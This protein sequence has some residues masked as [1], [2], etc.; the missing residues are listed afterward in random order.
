MDEMRRRRKEFQDEETPEKIE[1][2]GIKVY[3]G[4]VQ[5]IGTHSVAV[6][7][8]V[9]TGKHIVIATGSHSTKLEIPGLSPQDLLSNTS[10]FEID[11]DLQHLVIIGGGY[12]G[13]ELAE[14]FAGL[15]VKVT[16]VQRGSRI[17]PR[18]EPESSAIIHE[19][20]LSL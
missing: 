15:G 7:G 17:L 8:K 5:F 19:H 18:E 14:A 16:L 12:I 6:D 1:S 2:Y 11:F 9:L 20:L 3:T 13:C 4:N 10:I